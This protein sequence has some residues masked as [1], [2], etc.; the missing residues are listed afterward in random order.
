MDENTHVYCTH[1]KHYKIASD[2]TGLGMNCKQCPCS[3]CF[4][5]VPE[6]STAFKDRPFYKE[7]AHE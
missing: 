6:D 4:C 3:E 1:C 5:L 7:K 2:C